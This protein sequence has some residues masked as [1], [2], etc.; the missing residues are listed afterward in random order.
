MAGR[1]GH[2]LDILYGDCFRLKSDDKMDTSLKLKARVSQLAQEVESEWKMGGLSGT[3]YEE[4]AYEII[5]RY[6][7]DHSDELEDEDLIEDEIEFNPCD[8][9]DNHDACD[10]FGCAIK[11]G[12]REPNNW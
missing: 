11:Q 3:I 12:L 10:D 2:Y 5:R 1:C 4:F 9:C 8:D 7:F 6:L